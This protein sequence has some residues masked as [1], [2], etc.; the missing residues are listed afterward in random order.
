MK[1]ELKF[2]MWDAATKKMVDPYKITSLALDSNLKVDGIFIPF[3]GMP[4]MQFTGTRD[5]HNNEIFDGDIL[6]KSDPE[7]WSN[8]DCWPPDASM[9]KN[10]LLAGLAM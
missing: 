6:N 5:K 2:K 7:Y 1:I 3:N 8:P 4:I 9:I 10:Y